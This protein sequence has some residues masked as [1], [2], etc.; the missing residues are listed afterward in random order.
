MSK[1]EKPVKAAAKKPKSDVSAQVDK[2]VKAAVDKGVVDIAMSLP[3]GNAKAF[4]QTD[5]E[6]TLIEEKIADLNKAKRGCRGKLKELKVELSAYDRVRKLRKMAP[7]DRTSH[8]ASVA[9]Y[10]EQLGMG[11]SQYEKVLKKQLENQQEALADSI[12][13]LTGGN[14]GKEVGSGKGETPE[15]EAE[16]AP[17][18]VPERNQSL[19]AGGTT[20]PALAAAAGVH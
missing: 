15:A 12:A 20:R 13:D 18:G 8:E 11:L 9:L 1:K 19:S 14:S 10:K 2:N 7:E 17:A 6:L 3:A 5:K 16:E 4:V